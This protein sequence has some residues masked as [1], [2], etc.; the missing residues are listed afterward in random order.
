MFGILLQDGAKSAHNRCH[1]LADFHCSSDFCSSGKNS[2][3]L[4]L[5]LDHLCQLGDHLLQDPRLSEPKAFIKRT[6]VS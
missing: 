5:F 1:Q 2:P 3:L 6:E 4:C